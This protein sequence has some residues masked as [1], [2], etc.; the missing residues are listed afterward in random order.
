[1]K[2]S[3]RSRSP[4]NMLGG[5]PRRAPPPFGVGLAVML[6]CPEGGFSGGSS[7]GGAPNNGAFSVE[8]VGGTSIW[9]WV[10]LMWS[11]G[12]SCASLK[13]CCVAVDSPLDSEEEESSGVKWKLVREVKGAGAVGGS[14]YNR[15]PNTLLAAMRRPRLVWK[16]S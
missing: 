4:L 16:L 9:S 5:V 11:V 13:L 14:G 10:V 1:M 3:L 15:N 2:A 7:R 8:W 12:T 6:L